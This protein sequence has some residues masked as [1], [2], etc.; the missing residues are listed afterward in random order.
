MRSE[1]GYVVAVLRAGSLHV[2]QRGAGGN[3]VRVVGWHDV[4]QRVRLK[5][6]TQSI[7]QGR[8][9]CRNVH[10][11]TCSGFAGAPG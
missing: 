7:L 3:P 9:W 4:R 5:T 11:P 6:I 8:I 1:R 10:M 2:E